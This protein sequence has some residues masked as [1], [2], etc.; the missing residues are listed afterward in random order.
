MSATR[1]R[2]GA[3]FPHVAASFTSTFWQNSGCERE[4]ERETTFL[5]FGSVVF[6]FLLFCLHIIMLMRSPCWKKAKR[7][8][9]KKET[10]SLKTLTPS[11]HGYRQSKLLGEV[12]VFRWG[13]L[14]RS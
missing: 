12:A 9:N 5:G 14:L 4:I 7:T 2:R 3:L 1:V 8:K 13:W 6:V 11:G 10:R